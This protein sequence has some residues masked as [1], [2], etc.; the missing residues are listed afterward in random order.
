MVKNSCNCKNDNFS[1]GIG[2]FYLF[3]R[4][5]SAL[6]KHYENPRTTIVNNMENVNT[7]R[8]S[9]TPWR[10][11]YNHYRKTHSC[12]NNPAEPPADSQSTCKSN[13]KIVKDI[14]ECNDDGGI[15]IDCDSG[16]APSTSLVNKNGLKLAND[17]GNYK[18]YLYKRGKLFSQNATGL[19][20]ENRAINGGIHDPQGLYLYKIGFVNGTVVNNNSGTT[21][22]NDCGINIA[23]NRNKNKFST[24]TPPSYTKIPT[25]VKKYSNPKFGTSSSVSSRNRLQRLKYNTKLASQF[26]NCV[27]GEICSKYG[28]SKNVAAPMLFRSSNCFLLRSN[29]RSNNS[30]SSRLVCPQTLYRGRGSEKCVDTA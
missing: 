20:Q 2:S 12:T 13:E 3:R 15:L 22:K 30:N 11:P 28:S 5:N 9:N 16:K 4:Y 7:T 6:T 29:C 25:A 19:L 10:V 18:N 27:N 14:V 1:P 21:E 24:D 8:T 23:I 26:G 17:G